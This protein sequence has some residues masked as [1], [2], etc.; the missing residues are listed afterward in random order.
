MTDT[1]QSKGGKSRA[2]KL[3]AARIQDI[4]S[5]GG[6]ARS[7]KVKSLME[8]GDLIKATHQGKM[9][10]GDLDLDCYVLAD[11]RRLFHKRGMARALGMKSG[12]GNVFLRAVQRKGL[13]SEIDQKLLKK[14]E[15]PI[16]F[17]PLT[18]DL[19]HGYDAGVLVDICRAIIRAQES[20]K[21][22]TTQNGLAEQAKILL[23]AFAKVGVTALIDE[24]TG[25]Q[26]VRSPDAL[27]VLVQQYVEEERREWEKQFPDEYYDELNRLY[28]S[29]RLTTTGSGAII[30]NRP[31]HFAKFT[32]SYVYQPLANGAVLEELDR[33]NPK[34]DKK[35]TRKARFHQHL[36]NGYG[37]EKLKRQVGEVLT[38][39]KVSDSVTQFK[40]LFAR[41]FPQAGT[42][43]S[44]LDE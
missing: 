15:N 31:Q 9:L 28:G 39:I 16:V 13:G 10:V 5:S 34:I 19:G 32:R 44:F 21:L 14:I 2:T 29:K 36:N 35:G 12:G 30:Q 41:R 27:R 3:S 38:L 18:Q 42:Q 23:T 37:I 1:P 7:E 4:A 24:A 11:G 6:R 43:L 22:H 25:F 26:Q 17:K 20:G 33:L 40:K 8:S